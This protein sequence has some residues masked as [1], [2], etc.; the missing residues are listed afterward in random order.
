MLGYPL[1]FLTKIYAATGNQKYLETAELY[2]NWIKA[3]T[4]NLRNFFFSHK[5]AWGASCLAKTTQNESALKLSLD[6]SDYLVSIQEKNGSWLASY[7]ALM[8]YD[9]T[10]EIAIWLTEILNDLDS[11]S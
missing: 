10:P 2:F 5:V 9:Q 8:M 4:G 7:D 6:I 1:A 3:C 11:K